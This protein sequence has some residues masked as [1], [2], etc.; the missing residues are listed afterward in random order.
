MHT[1]GQYLS[2]DGVHCHLGHEISSACT[3]HSVWSIEVYPKAAN[4]GPDVLA[5]AGPRAPL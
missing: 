2:G 3:Y 4:L 1:F 5:D